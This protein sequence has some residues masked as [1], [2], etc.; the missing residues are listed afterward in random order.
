MRHNNTYIYGL[1]S[2]EATIGQENDS[3]CQALREHWSLNPRPEKVKDPLFLEEEFFD[4]RDFVQVKYE[5]LRRVRVEEQ[6][7]TEASSAFGLS[8]PAYYKAQETFEREG[9]AGLIPRKRGPRRR[10]KLSKE[11]VRFLE[12]TLE[13]EG[14]LSPGTLV[15]LVEERFGLRVHRRTIERALGAAKKKQR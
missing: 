11:V 15:E 6:T 10:H 13:R 2:K 4:P 12:E 3:K 14:R 7:V 8:R 1:S 9:L 5:M